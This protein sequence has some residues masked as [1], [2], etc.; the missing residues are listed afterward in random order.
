MF[1]FYI[2]GVGISNIWMIQ[3]FLNNC[4]NSVAILFNFS[5]YLGDIL[6]RVSELEVARRDNNRES[7][8][9]W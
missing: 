4:N 5:W 8:E 7:K 9:H 2:P 6:V 3:P 1:L